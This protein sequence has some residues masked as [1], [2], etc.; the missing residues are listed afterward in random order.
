MW[1]QELKTT[2]LFNIGPSGKTSVTRGP[3]LP[4][5][6]L[7]VRLFLN[8][9]GTTALFLDAS[10]VLAFGATCGYSEA[11]SSSTLG[12]GYSL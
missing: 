4:G 10:S 5:G 2:S 3:R 12:S 11:Y 7:C 6:L 9:C 8:F 1:E